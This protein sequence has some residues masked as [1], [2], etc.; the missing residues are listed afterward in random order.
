[1]E[2][3]L[4]LPYARMILRNPLGG[5]M[6]ESQLRVMMESVL[7]VMME[8]A[9]THARNGPPKC[10]V[11][12][13]FGT[14]NG[15]LASFRFSSLFSLCLWCRNL[16]L[17]MSSGAERLFVAAVVSVFFFVFPPV[18][19][20][21]GGTSTRVVVVV[22]VVVVLFFFPP[23]VFDESFSRKQSNEGKRREGKKGRK[24]CRKHKLFLL[25]FLSSSL[26]FASFRFWCF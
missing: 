25:S 26:S 20:R 1:M 19:E 11:M 8:P 7:R 14:Q 2:L 13:V 18:C 17:C 9:T 16:A 10:R 22:V 15:A 24:A 3:V 4:L 5:V 6:M 21:D 12:I 23:L